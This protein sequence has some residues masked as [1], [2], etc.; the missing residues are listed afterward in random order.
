MRIL[1][2]EDD[3]VLRGVMLRSLQDA[4]HRVDAAFSLGETRHFWQVQPYDTVLL[5][6]NLPKETGEDV[7]LHMR[8][9][10]RCKNARVL[11]VTSSDSVSDRKAMEALGVNGFFRKPSDYAEYLKLGSIVKALLSDCQT[12]NSGNDLA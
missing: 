12:A 4:G 5:D 11:V 10:V 7:L 3:V 1:L 2:V 6:L 9:S 8:K